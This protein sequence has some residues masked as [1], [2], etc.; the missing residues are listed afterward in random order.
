MSTY[1]LLLLLP[2]VQV[3]TY[4][5]L[6]IAIER[7]KS[8]LVLPCQCGNPHI[9]LLNQLPFGSQIG[10]NSAIN[11]GRIF[12]GVDELSTMAVAQVIVKVKQTWAVM[13]SGIMV[14]TIIEFANNDVRNENVVIDR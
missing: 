12:I 3:K 5:A 9:V 6:I 7:Q 4:H 2:Y 11:N 1:F 14:G 13:N 10:G 8:E